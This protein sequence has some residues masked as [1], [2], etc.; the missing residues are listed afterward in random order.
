MSIP[1]VA[2]PKTPDAVAGLAQRV[3]LRAERET[4]RVDLDGICKA[5]SIDVEVRAMEN[6][7]IESLLIPSMSGG[8][9]VIVREQA[10]RGYSTSN[11]AHRLRFRVAHEIA[12][13]L[14]YD[15]GFPPRRAI[16]HS[17]E[18]ELFCD[19]FARAL[20][21]PQERVMDVRD[22]SRIFAL[23]DE[24]DVSLQLVAHAVCRHSNV[25]GIRAFRRTG[26][27]NWKC[28]WTVGA[29]FPCK[30]ELL[31]Q[32]WQTPEQPWRQSEGF[33]CATAMRKGAIML[34][35]WEA[36]DS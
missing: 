30:A 1:L 14:F 2:I 9:S 36:P 16:R 5:S 35:V 13:S 10:I 22:A 23:R 3:R 29:N 17:P 25:R 18:E 31:E 32:S 6:T 34:G 27:E 20:L 15:D 12:H 24:L 28:V 21:V 19:E 33:G 26:R 11:T 4:T 8:F 7:T